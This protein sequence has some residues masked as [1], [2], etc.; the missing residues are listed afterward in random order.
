MKPV[1]I[2]T[3]DEIAFL[4]KTYRLRGT[5]Y[6]V[7]NLDRWSYIQVRA[8]IQKLKLTL[9]PG[10]KSRINVERGKRRETAD[11]KI[12]DALIRKYHDEKT[13]KDI[14]ITAGVKRYYVHFRAKKLGL[15]LLHAETARR[16]T[17]KTIREQ[18]EGNLNDIEKL[19]LYGRR[20]T[21]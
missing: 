6:C 18:M 2:W 9:D 8:K 5:H 21:A 1:H 15:K 4:V 19:A 7:D 17:K 12:V 10:T 13:A 16:K 20:I 3:D 11:A 14:S